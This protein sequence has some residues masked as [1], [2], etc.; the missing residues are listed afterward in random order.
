MNVFLMYF[1]DALDVRC[2]FFEL[3]VFL[4]TVVAAD[5]P[6]YLSVSSPE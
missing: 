1:S 6:T 3:V 2:S 5:E 4:T